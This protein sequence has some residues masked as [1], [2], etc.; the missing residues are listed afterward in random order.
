MSTFVSLVDDY[1]TPPGMEFGPDGTAQPT[2][3]PR[4]NADI[5]TNSVYWLIGREQMIAAG[6]QESQP[7]EQFSDTTALI[8]RIICIVV[9]PMLVLLAGGV[10]WTV[11]RK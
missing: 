9:L 4:D 2:D 3:P 8:V 1:I 7:I 5:V 10:M 11:R 6:P